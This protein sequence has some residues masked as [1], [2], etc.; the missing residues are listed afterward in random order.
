M[1]IVSLL[2]V[3]AFTGSVVAQDDAVE[4]KKKRLAEILKQFKSLEVEAEKLMEELTG[5]DQSKQDKLIEEVLTKYA[6][7]MKAEM[8]K[9]RAVANERNAWVS[10]RTIGTAQVDF[11]SNDRDNNMINDFWVRDISGLYRIRPTG[12][13]DWSI[14][15]IELSIALADAKPCVALDKKGECKLEGEKQSV[16]LEQLEPGAPKAGYNFVVLESYE[17]ENG[18]TVKYDNGSGRSQSTFGVC[19]YPADTAKTPKASTYIMSEEN[20]VWKKDTGGKPATTFPLKPAEAGW[21]KP[22]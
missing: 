20:V 22:D 13:D 7:E 12:G 3:F 1:R 6:P 11:R 4:A 17:D 8:D 9:A 5:G 21:V 15:L 16:T 10:L 18:K 14:K 2:L 19:A